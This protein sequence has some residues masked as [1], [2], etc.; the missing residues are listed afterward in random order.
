MLGGGKK[1]L[2]V[3]I[4]AAL[5]VAAPLAFAQEAAE[6]TGGETAGGRELVLT[7]GTTASIN[8]NIGLG[9]VSAGNTFLVENDVNLRYSS[10][11]SNQTFFVEA[12]AALRLIDR[13]SGGM[14]ADF[15][16]PAY[17]FGYARE[18]ARSRLSFDARYSKRDLTFTSPFDDPLDDDLDL[19]AVDGTRESRDIGVTL[20]TGIDT[21]L[22]LTLEARSSRRDYSETIDPDLF[23]VDRD[24]LSATARLKLSPVT[25]GTLTASYEDYAADDLEQI[26]RQTR[27]LSFGVEQEVSASTL[28]TAS[29]DWTAI[30]TQGSE[31]GVPFDR[32]TAGI[33]ASLGMSRELRNGRASA[34]LASERESS[35]SRTT[36][37]F[38]RDLEMPGAVISATAG[39]TRSPRGDVDGIAALAYTREMKRG[40]IEASFNRG[41]SVDEDDIDTDLRRTRFSLGYTT[42]VNSLSSLEFT[43]DY[44]REEATTDTADVTRANLRAAYN[45]ELTRD[46]D[47]SVG[48][49]WEKRDEVGAGSGT[50][51]SV[52]LSLDRSFNFRP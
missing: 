40:V 23:D 44:A 34:R 33:G 15:T 42:E 7:F 47:M 4:A 22:G 14:T 17:R 20:E 30:D 1:K 52:F 48:Y 39:V 5:A 25:T 11:T 24:S 46:W 8:D 38:S 31:L 10:T 13:P 6:T 16:D 35:G 41:V 28:L 26:E 21:P 29:I 18:G 3:A 19:E 32:S 43:F 2:A 50:A 51:N 45:R 27:E 36:L 49:L 9:A 12:D 37:T